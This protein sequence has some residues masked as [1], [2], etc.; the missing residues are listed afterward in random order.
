VIAS[1]VFLE[2]YGAIKL[3]IYEGNGHRHLLAV[4]KT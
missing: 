2:F 1:E 4:D 3:E